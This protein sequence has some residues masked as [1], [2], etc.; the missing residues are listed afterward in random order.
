MGFSD[1]IWPFQ[2]KFSEI[3]CA[4]EAGITAC[5]GGPATGALA[6][7]ATGK[8]RTTFFATTYSAFIYFWGTFLVLR[9]QYTKTKQQ[10]AL[11]KEAMETNKLD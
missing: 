11:F 10:S 7:I 6:L 9:Y 8:P 3:P 4:R 2:R 5:L 1:Y